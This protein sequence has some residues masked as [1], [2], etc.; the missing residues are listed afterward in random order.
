[1]TRSVLN[2]PIDFLSH[3]F[4]RIGLTRAKALQTVSQFPRETRRRYAAPKS[5]AFTLHR[6][7]VY[8]DMAYFFTYV[9]TKSK[10]SWPIED[11]APRGRTRFFRAK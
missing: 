3:N 2:Y 5:N 8:L 1:M 6:F 4:I 9:H 7:C 10:E 11:P